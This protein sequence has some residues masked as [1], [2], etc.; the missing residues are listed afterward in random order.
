VRVIGAFALVFVLVTLGAFAWM[1]IT[2]S[3]FLII[4]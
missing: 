2:G 1:Q 3:V 4:E